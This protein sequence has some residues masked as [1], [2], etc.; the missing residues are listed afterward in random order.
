ML[1]RTMSYQEDPLNEAVGEMASK[2]ICSLAENNA[3]QL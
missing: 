2:C 3:K 1:K